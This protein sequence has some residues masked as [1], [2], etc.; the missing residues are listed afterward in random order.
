MQWL[1]IEC[2][3]APGHFDLLER[4]GSV[5]HDALASVCLRLVQDL[6]F[7]YKMH[8]TTADAKKTGHVMSEMSVCAK[9]SKRDHMLVNATRG[10]SIQRKIRVQVEDL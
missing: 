10:T 4:R 1:K 7:D 6:H 9:K 3:P 8:I 2:T 5:S